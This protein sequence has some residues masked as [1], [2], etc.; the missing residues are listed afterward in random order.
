MAHMTTAMSDPR[1]DQ[2]KLSNLSLRQITNP[3][4]HFGM[5]CYIAIDK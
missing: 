5:V 4:N 2:K 1:K 3:Q